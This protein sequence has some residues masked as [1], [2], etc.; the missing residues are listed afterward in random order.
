MSI[1]FSPYVCGYD[2]LRIVWWLPFTFVFLGLFNFIV[3]LKN[4]CFEKQMLL[5]NKLSS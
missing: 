3:F 1:F 4:M 2:V 5:T